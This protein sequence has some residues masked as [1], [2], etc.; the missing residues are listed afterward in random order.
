MGRNQKVTS[1]EVF[2]E[3]KDRGT[4]TKSELADTFNVC[5]QTICNKLKILR[6]DGEK[7]IH[8]R[9]GIFYL[10]AIVDEE[11]LRRFQNYEKWVF[12]TLKGLAI[13]AKPTKQ[14][15]KD[16]SE[17]LKLNFDKA[18]RRQIKKYHLNQLRLLD[19]AE[20]EEELED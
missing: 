16:S 17:Y 13:C 11:S 8:D 14:I 18:T 15:W 3:I 10:D 12:E 20:L 1:Q 5:P 7:I 4:V 2:E 6:K 9:D 19:Y